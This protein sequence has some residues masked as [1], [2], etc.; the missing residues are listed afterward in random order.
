MKIMNRQ[1][2]QTLI[3][4][5]AAVALFAVVAAAQD[6]EIKRPA[7]SVPESADL[8]ASLVPKGWRIEAETLN[9]AD[10]NGDGRPDAAFVISN[11]GSDATGADASLVVKHVLVLALRGSDGRLHRSLVNDAAVLDGDEGGV[12]GDP[13]Q[14]LSV[15]RGAI[16]IGH[17]GG[18]RDRWSFTH[19]YR[20]QNE[21]W[22]LIGLTIGN[23][24]TL[25]LEHF[26][27]QDINLSTG[28]VQ[29]GEKG[30]DD[31]ERQK[32]E[33][34]GSYYELEAPL[35]DKAP[36]IDGQVAADEWP[37]YNVRL[38]QKQHVLRNPQLWRDANDLSVKLHAVYSGADLFLCAE[39]TDNEVT[40]GDA[41]RLVNKRGLVIKPLESKLVPNANGYIFEA[42]YS[43]KAMAIALKADDKYIVENV[44]MTIDPSSDYADAQGFQLRASVEVVDVD[45][46]VVPGARAVVSTRL[47]GSPFTGA[48]RIFRKG[49]LVL[50]SDSEQ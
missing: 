20:F 30:G 40:A 9:Q 16:V 47:A 31:E 22:T 48:I 38:N 10:L 14:S 27:N 37:G 21:K 5:C 18:S 15:E 25:N 1:I 4:C 23:T 6:P 39:V 44:E 24:D 45:K 43:L 3:R 12:M 49:T 35:I 36:M 42:R 41:V 8:A 11:G 17:Y 32:P 29:A 13:F 2:F 46:S 7:L 50:V 34:S 19:R 26:D 33:R 28:L